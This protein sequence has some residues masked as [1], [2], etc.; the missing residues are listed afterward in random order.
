MASVVG[1]R[2][3]QPKATDTVVRPCKPL[4]RRFMNDHEL[5]R[6]GWDGHRNQQGNRGGRA[7]RID[8]GLMKSDEDG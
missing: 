2:G 7:R 8:W 4:T 3:G 6:G 5:A 1:K